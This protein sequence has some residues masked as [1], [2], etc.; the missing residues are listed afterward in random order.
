MMIVAFKVKKYIKFF[1]CYI[2]NINKYLRLSILKIGSRFSSVLDFERLSGQSKI[3][4]Y[5]EG[6]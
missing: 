5:L 3:F 2:N 6:E 4:A 1:F